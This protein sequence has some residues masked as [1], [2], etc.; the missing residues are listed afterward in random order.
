VATSTASCKPVSALMF[1]NHSSALTPL[2]SN[3]PARVRGFQTPARRIFVMFFEAN[4]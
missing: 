1:A 3:P 4:A 2:P